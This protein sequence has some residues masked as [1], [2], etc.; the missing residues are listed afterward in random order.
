MKTA[1]TVVQMLIRFIGLIQV[2]MGLVFW[3]GTANSL[4]SI[5][6]LLG[7]LLVILLWVMAG[8]AARARVPLG[9]VALA[10]VWGLVV[11]ALG[12]TQTRLMLNNFHWV[13]RVAHLLVGLGAMGIAETLA[14]RIKRGQPELARRGDTASV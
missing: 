3:T 6:M 5:H 9:L 4:V 11:V 1:L 7:I 13:I 8:F 14:G 2:V 10:V 12:M